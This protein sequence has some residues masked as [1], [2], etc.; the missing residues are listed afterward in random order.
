MQTPMDSYNKLASETT[1]E[2]THI[3][4]SGVSLLGFSQLVAPINKNESSKSS[5]LHHP[6]GGSFPKLSWHLDAKAKMAPTIHSA[7]RTVLQ[8]QQMSPE[9][10]D[11]YMSSLKSLDRYNKPFQMIWA[12]LEDKNINPIQAT[13]TQ[14]VSALIELEKNFHSTSQKC[15][16]WTYLFSTVST[17]EICHPA[18]SFKK[19]MEL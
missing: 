2:P 11:S 10:L 3:M 9:A 8:E 18:S 6:P 16:Q 15:L 19:E 17:T 1:Q 14:I 7:L 5:L 4:P 12:I 13:I